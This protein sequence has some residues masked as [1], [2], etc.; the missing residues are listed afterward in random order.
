MC[1]VKDCMN[2]E[3]EYVK[4]RSYVC[5]RACMY[6]TVIEHLTALDILI[7]L[8]APLVGPTTQQRRLIY[9]HTYLHMYGHTYLRRHVSI[10]LCG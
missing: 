6:Y 2:V 10:Y 7:E 9:I 3:R 8:T 4:I 5:M 1:A